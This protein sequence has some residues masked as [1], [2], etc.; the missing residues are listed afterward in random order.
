MGILATIFA[1]LLAS[2]ASASVAASPQENLSTATPVSCPTLNVQNPHRSTNAGG[3]IVK[4]TFQCADGIT[5]A[6]ANVYLRYCG[7]EPGGYCTLAAT[8]DRTVP[9]P[10]GG[11][12]YTAYAPNVGTPPPT[13]PG[14]YQGSMQ[15]DAYNDG[16]VVASTTATGNLVYV[17]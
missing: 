7:P 11:A 6:I 14:Y 17:P 9:Y 10:V 1:L 4:G 15:V 8:G 2:P 5:T 3:I 12:P 13:Q 16:I